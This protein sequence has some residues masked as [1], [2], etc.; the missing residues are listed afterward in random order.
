MSFKLETERL[1]IRHV[2]PERDFEAWVDCFAD[3]ET[4]TFIGVVLG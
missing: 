3:K 1:I 2:D 4:M